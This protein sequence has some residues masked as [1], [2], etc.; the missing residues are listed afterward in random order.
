[1]EESMRH[2]KQVA[3]RMRTARDRIAPEGTERRR[4]CDAAVR[5]L[6]TALSHDA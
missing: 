4:V 3:H 2:W 5:A 1:M 6:K